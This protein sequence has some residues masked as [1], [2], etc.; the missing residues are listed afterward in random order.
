MKYEIR[1]VCVCV[2]ILFSFD[3]SGSL[4]QTQALG[5]QASVTTARGLS[6]CG[7][8]VLEHRPNSCAWAS[9]PCSS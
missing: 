1:V 5:K 8:Q 3:C 6:S 4:L 9:L 7:S 2:L